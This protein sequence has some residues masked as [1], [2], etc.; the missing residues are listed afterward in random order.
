MSARFALGVAGALAGL[1][2]LGSRRGSTA[3]RRGLGRFGA[4]S[5]RAR[6]TGLF[7]RS[8]FNA[9][10]ASLQGLLGGMVTDGWDVMPFD[11]SSYTES[12]EY[13]AWA[14]SP[15]MG[16]EHLGW[17]AFRSVFDVGRGRVVKID[18]GHGGIDPDGFIVWNGEPS[19]A[20][21][22]E[23]DLWAAATPKQREHLVPTL[24]VDRV[25]GGRWI[26]MEKTVPLA[27]WDSDD[28]GGSSA[29]ML[30]ASRL[31]PDDTR[32]AARSLGIPD[33]EVNP[34][35]LDA[36]FRLLDYGTRG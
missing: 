15:R 33:S 23:W 22:V 10:Y 13:E 1:A 34:Y 25:G 3:H 7:E 11:G 21:L 29:R 28:Q 2:A 9:L 19:G 20:N 26:V 18:H 24:D 12:F 17:G 32:Q 6:A 27:T 14:D 30:A 16:L 4:V 35:N 36:R 5:E 31:I 8:R